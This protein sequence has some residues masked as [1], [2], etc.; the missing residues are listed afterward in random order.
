MFQHHGD[1][2]A[3]NRI[4]GQCQSFDGQNSPYQVGST[5]GWGWF[6]SWSAYC[7]ANSA[8]CGLQTRIESFQH[9]G[10][11]TALNDVHLFCCEK[12]I[13]KLFFI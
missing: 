10:D 8:V 4:N 3:A 2:T 6:G 5:G 12:D 1:D 13:S 9:H 7:P 11:D